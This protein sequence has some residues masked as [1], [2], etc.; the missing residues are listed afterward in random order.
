MMRRC[1]PAPASRRHVRG[2]VFRA[3]CL[4]HPVRSTNR[5]SHRPSGRNR[6]RRGPNPPGSPSKCPESRG[7]RYLEPRSTSSR[8][9]AC[10]QSTGLSREPG[11]R[12]AAARSRS[13]HPSRVGSSN[14]PDGREV[15]RTVERSRRTRA[16]ISSKGLAGREVRGAHRAVP[17]TPASAGGAVPRT[18]AAPIRPNRAHPREP[19]PQGETTLMVRPESFRWTGGRL[20]SRA[21][22]DRHGLSLEPARLDCNGS[23]PDGNRYDARPRGRTSPVRSARRTTRR[24]AASP[25]RPPACPSAETTTKPG[26]GH[27]APWSVE[28][29][30]TPVGARR[31]C[32]ASRRRPG[33]ARKPSS[34]CRTGAAGSGPFIPG[35]DPGLDFGGR[36]PATVRSD[37]RGSR[38]GRRMIESRRRW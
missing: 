19:V 32:S 18:F 31:R 22:P 12:R 17:G 35:L 13:M 11:A 23:T 20:Y 34:R 16:V 36:G 33:T 9:T 38:A 27:T 30:G 3:G 2:G 28:G 21:A 15:S 26:I 8:S 5:K 6:P 25:A 14:I 37:G 4:L 10:E 1:R 29:P 7:G 24:S